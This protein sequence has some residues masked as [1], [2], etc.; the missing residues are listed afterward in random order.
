M[1]FGVFLV[2]WHSI[3][4]YDRVRVFFKCIIELSVGGLERCIFLVASLHD[5]TVSCALISCAQETAGHCG[6]AG[7][8]RSV[9]V[10]GTSVCLVL[11]SLGESHVLSSKVLFLKLRKLYEI[12]G[13]FSLH[14]ELLAE[15][16]MDWDD[17][18]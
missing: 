5:S 1:Y 8:Y 18:A 10:Q 7:R 6:W 3:V 9:Q 16:A 15:V 2:P 12:L 11:A 14:L 13:K 17:D 4:I